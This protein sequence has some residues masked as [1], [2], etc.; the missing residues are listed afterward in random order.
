MQL[1]NKMTNARGDGT[2]VVCKLQMQDL[3]FLFMHEQFIDFPTFA[4]LITSAVLF[5]R[6]G[7]YA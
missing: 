3:N 6:F 7:C 2:S 5:R 4:C 1:E